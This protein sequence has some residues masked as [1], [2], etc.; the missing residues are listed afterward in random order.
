MP[1]MKFRIF[2]VLLGLV[3][4][5]AIAT[6]QVRAKLNRAHK[7]LPVV[8]LIPYEKY[9]GER[10][11][12]NPVKSTCALAKEFQ[13]LKFEVTV[14]SDDQ[15]QG[16]LTNELGELEG[17]TISHA[18]NAT[19]LKKSIEAWVNGHFGLKEASPP[20]ALIGFS[21]HGEERG[22]STEQFFLTTKCKSGQDGYSIRGLQQYIGERDLP[23]VL[24]VD[25]CRERVAAKPPQSQE[26]EPNVSENE[27][28]SRAP[29]EAAKELTDRRRRTGI[30][31]AVRPYGS[32]GGQRDQH[33]DWPVTTMWATTSGLLAPDK[34]D[35]F[36][37]LANGMQCPNG[38][39]SFQ[40]RI[41]HPPSDGDEFRT[42]NETEL[43]FWVWYHYAYGILGNT[44]ERNFPPLLQPGTVDQMMICASRDP[45]HEY[46][47]IT[48]LLSG[49]EIDQINDMEVGVSTQGIVVTRPAGTDDKS[50]LWVAGQVKH[51]TD[52]S[53]K[54]IHVDILAQCL[55]KIPDTKMKAMFQPYGTDGKY[56]SRDWNVAQDIPWG[57]QYTFPIPL[58][59]VQAGD[60]LKG[61]AISAAPL[62]LD[63]WPVGCSLTVTGMRLM[64]EDRSQSTQNVHVWNL[65]GRWWSLDNMTE[66]KRNTIAT[67]AVGAK[68][69]RSWHLQ[70]TDKN[71][72]QM[73]GRGGPLFPAL[74]ID[75]GTQHMELAI[76]S[77]RP[78]KGSRDR[79][80]KVILADEGGILALWEESIEAKMFNK[81]QRIEIL[82]SGKADYLAI[83][84]DSE[85]LEIS[86]LK[87]V[88]SP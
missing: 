5:T 70:V 41:L 60:V 81:P 79:T 63:G 13:K 40:A 58:N 18:N 73:A 37:V 17:V 34:N 64:S 45:N 28:T 65:M 55:G 38:K 80:V 24:V 11:L 85:D 2:V 19:D 8:L 67:I 6:A 32:K 4:A 71:E 36:S 1:Y 25:T 75:S 21:G 27:T 29:L 23:V 10:A 50:K 83:M 14:I 39:K 59:Q 33:A 68:S 26:S 9:E 62:Q 31:I 22:E 76:K 43:P 53:G 86:S 78:F 77:S 82:R 84:T 16:D 15:S 7:K 87:I 35:L 66:G 54:V 48:D 88:P 56:S 74:S 30:Q 20:Y 49:W 57:R 69:L 61:V 52:L 44:P 47:T 12:F 46:E 72:G 51:V 3:T 42:D